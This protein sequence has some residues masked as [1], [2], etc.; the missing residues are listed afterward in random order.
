M[1]KPLEFEVFFGD[2]P[3]RDYIKGIDIISHFNNHDYFGRAEVYGA[4]VKA[5]QFVVNWGIWQVLD[6]N[7]PSDFRGV[8]ELQGWAP[9]SFEA[10]SIPFELDNPSWI[11]LWGA[12]NNLAKALNFQDCSHSVASFTRMEDNSLLVGF[13]MN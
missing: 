13:F 2:P 7:A 10:K 4:V 3:S 8:K 11:E 1:N 9:F 5:N 6:L 12:A